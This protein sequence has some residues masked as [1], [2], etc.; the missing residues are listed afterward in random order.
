MKAVLLLHVCESQLTPTSGLLRGRAAYE[1]LGATRSQCRL[2]SG[3]DDELV[4][5][6]ASV[7]V[8][9]TSREDTIL[10]ARSHFLQFCN[11]IVF[12]ATA[13]A[14]KMKRLAFFAMLMVL[15]SSLIY[16]ASAATAGEWRMSRCELIMQLVAGTT[17][18]FIKIAAEDTTTSA[19]TLNKVHAAEFKSNEHSTK[20]PTVISTKDRVTNPADLTNNTAKSTA[21]TSIDTTATSKILFDNPT[22]DQPA[23]EGDVDDAELTTENSVVEVETTA[24]PVVEETESEEKI[25]QG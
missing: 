2:L 18:M 10:K 19:T 12:A 1:P 8:A 14:I 21:A 7:D 15:E 16:A 11:L 22:E 3:G 23:T 5:S 4:G 6:L 24:I 13:I 17:R 20:T 25:T 9:V